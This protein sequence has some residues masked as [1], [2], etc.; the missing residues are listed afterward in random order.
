MEESKNII[1]LK[2]KIKEEKEDTIN[3]ITSKIK[4]KEGDFKNLKIDKFEEEKKKIREFSK[5]FLSQWKNNKVI[6]AHELTQFLDLLK[7]DFGRIEFSKELISDY[8]TNKV[9]FFYFLIIMII[10][11]KFV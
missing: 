3:L 2:S 10:I 5:K 1:K 7:F 8:N 11:R 9:S 4:I 6:E